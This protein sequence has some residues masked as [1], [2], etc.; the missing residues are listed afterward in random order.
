MLPRSLQDF[1]ELQIEFDPTSFEMAR[2]SIL[3][4]GDER[5]DFIFSNVKENVSVPSAEFVFKAPP[6]VE[7]RDN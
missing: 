6:G 2:L 7:V 5:S 4:S 3:K 1:E